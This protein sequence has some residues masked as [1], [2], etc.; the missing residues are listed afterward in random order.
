MRFNDRKTLRAR[1]MRPSRRFGVGTVLFGYIHTEG[2]NM[3]L[4]RYLSLVSQYE[5]WF[6]CVLMQVLAMFR[7]RLE[8]HQPVF[9]KFICLRGFNLVMEHFFYIGLWLYFCY[10]ML[11]LCFCCFMSIDHR[12]SNLCAAQTLYQGYLARD[13][14]NLP[15]LQET[16]GTSW[17]SRIWRMAW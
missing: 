12:A 8:L 2:V 9:V 4:L 6:G 1:L 16:A 11:W 5:N 10:F 14:E 13:V 15:K 17:I 3:W 7:K